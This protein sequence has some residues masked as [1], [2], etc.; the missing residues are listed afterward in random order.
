MVN[1][2]IGQR[3]L[4]AFR[5]NRCKVCTHPGRPL[6]E[7]QIL[8]NATYPSIVEWVSNH[9][10]EEIDGVLVEWPILTV[11]QLLNHY[12]NG[13]CPLDAKLIHE[14]SEQRMAEL[15]L[16]YEASSGRIV[17]HVV[18]A[19]LIAALGQERLIKGEIQP[20]VKDTLAAA[21]FIAD[22]EAK[23]G[24]PEGDEILI[25]WQQAMEVFFA[26]TQR[27]VSPDQWQAIGADLSSNP[28]LRELTAKMHAHPDEDIH[29]AE[30]I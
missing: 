12:N 18:A 19:K 21:K 20:D 24:G 2:R 3:V 8:L 4:P 23:R 14:L 26:V 9:E 6:I 7:E 13:H 17:D 16:D 29:D 28:V 11:H 27:H 30:L 5:S 25:I 15:G 22:L 10:V 1:I